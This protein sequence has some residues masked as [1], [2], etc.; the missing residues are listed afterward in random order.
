[1]H[2][3][4]PLALVIFSVLGLLALLA[5]RKRQASSGAAATVATSNHK[6]VRTFQYGP[7]PVLETPA[8]APELPVTSILSQLLPEKEFSGSRS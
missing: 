2:A 8:A 4:L 7:P 5:W 1:M 6:S 3:F